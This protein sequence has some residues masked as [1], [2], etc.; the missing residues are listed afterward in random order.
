MTRVASWEGTFLLRGWR[1]KKKGKDL[2]NGRKG[3]GKRRKKMASDANE[4]RCW[5][6]FLP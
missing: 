2:K 5:W 3:G 1:E 4:G 6:G